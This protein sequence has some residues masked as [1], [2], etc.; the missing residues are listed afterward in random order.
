MHEA[1]DR[2]QTHT[3]EIQLKELYATQRWDCLITVRANEA[4]LSADR[5]NVR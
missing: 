4:R 5:K 1:R 3:L 2:D